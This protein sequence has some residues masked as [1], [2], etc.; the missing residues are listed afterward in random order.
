MKLF[1]TFL[2]ISMNSLLNAQ[3]TLKAIN[4]FMYSEYYVLNND[5]SF[6]YSYNHCTGI[7]IGIGTYK[8]TILG[9]IK[10]LFEK[11]R[12][13]NDTIVKEFNVDSDSI[14]IQVLSSKDSSFLGGII[15]IRHIMGM[16]DEY[17]LKLLQIQIQL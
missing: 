17:F 4:T 15:I 2:L 5:N 3:D 10:F 9:N 7:E 6:E 8:K 1:I 14:S 16:N 12:I 13:Q 11:Y